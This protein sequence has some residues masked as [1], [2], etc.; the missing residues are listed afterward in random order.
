MSQIRALAPALTVL[1]AASVLNGVLGVRWLFDGAERF[2]QTAA[3]WEFAAYQRVHL[4]VLV[5]LVLAVPGLGA[6]R[7]PTGKRL[8][9]GVLVA[10]VGVTVLQAGTVFAM[11]F[12][13]PF[14]AEVAPEVV[15]LENGGSFAVAMSAVWV[16]FTLVLVAAGV[17]VWRSRA[18]PRS[19]GVLLVVGGLVMPPLGPVGSVL[20]GAALLRAGLSRRARDE[21]NPALPAPAIAH[22]V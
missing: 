13:A 14:Y 4:L 11:A 8:S 1:G 15:D 18:L 17:S 3:T 6:L 10:L 20:V 12:V 5:G 2:S 16:A 21:T 9:P 7:G 19:C 22:S